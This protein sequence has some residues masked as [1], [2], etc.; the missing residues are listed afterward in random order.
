MELRE[1]RRLTLLHTADERQLT[2]CRLGPRSKSPFQGQ[3]GPPGA[4]RMHLMNETSPPS[5][6]RGCLAGGF[7]ERSRTREKGRGHTRQSEEQEPSR[8]DQLDA[9]LVRLLRAPP[10]GKLQRKVHKEIDLGLG[11]TDVGSRGCM[12]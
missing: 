12:S 11:Q 10:I 4:T 5:K 9:F 8:R 3:P 7:A 1:A 2:P 6:R